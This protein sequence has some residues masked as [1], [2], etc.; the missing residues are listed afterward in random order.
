MMTDHVLAPPQ[1]CSAPPDPG[2]EPPE[3]PRLGDFGWNCAVASPWDFVEIS[4]LNPGGSN[5]SSGSGGVS[6]KRLE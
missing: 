2:L 6:R 4:S 3:P 5:G 1:R